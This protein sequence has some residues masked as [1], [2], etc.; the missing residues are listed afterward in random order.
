MLKKLA[1]ILFITS[2]FSCHSPTPAI[3]DVSYIDSLITNYQTVKTVDNNLDFWEKRMDSLP[4]NFVNGPEYASALIAGF[5]QHG[6]IRDLNKAD[7]LMHQSNMANQE[8]EPGIWRSLAG[9]AM[10]R[11][12]FL[13]ANDCLNKAKLIEGNSFPNAFLEFDILFERG[14]YYKAKA[15]LTSLKAGNEYGYLF[16]RSKYEHYDGSL[17]SSIACMSRAGEK[18][19]NNIYLKQAAFSNTADLYIHKGDL[20]KAYEFYIKSIKTGHPDLHSITGLGWIALVHDRNDSLAER[21]FQFVHQQTK[22]PDILFKLSQLEEA[23]GDTPKQ[24]KYA[25]EFVTIVSDSLY[26]RM[27]NKYLIDLY[28]G[29]LQ[30]PAKAVAL[31]EAEINDRPNPQVY[32]WY[33]WSLFCNKEDEKAWNIYKAFVS[34]KPLEGPELYYMGKMMEGMK[35]GYNAKEFFKAASKN[36][37]DLDPAKQEDLRKTLDL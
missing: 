6:D 19:G 7:S 18:A 17:D 25:E 10:L 9:L 28:T 13:I 4:D 29:V 20:E 14:N 32:A 21:I 27:Y 24:K 35:K 8:K 5:R 2:L 22:A 11:H 26:G 3:V 30:T 16:R 23:K 31:A 37:Y 12:Q 15:F 33:A 1:G 36:I 34:G